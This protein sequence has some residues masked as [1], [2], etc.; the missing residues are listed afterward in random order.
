MFGNLVDRYQRSPEWRSLAPRTRILRE[1]LLL[2]ARAFLG[3]FSVASLDD[4]RTKKEIFSWRD[5]LADTPAKADNAIRTLSAMLSWAVERTEIEINW[6][7]KIKMLSPKAPR[8]K[9]T[10]TPGREEILLAT[11]P[12]PVNQLYRFA[13]FTLARESDIAAMRPENFDGRWLV[14]IPE[15]TKRKG[16]EVHLP[17]FEL[18]PLAALLDEIGS[19]WLRTSRGKFWTA[20]NI[21]WRFGDAVRKAFPGE[22]IDRTFH[23]IRGTGITRLMDA[24]C[25]DTETAAISGHALGRGSVLGNYIE[26]NR[27]QAVNAYRKWARAMQHGEADIIPFRRLGG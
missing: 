3:D 18:P 20:A 21:R 17:V 5:S 7:S 26:R 11:A 4:K 16:I 19:D 24:G 15:K 13:L 2:E 27:Q 14:F 10:W 8:A 1:A 12:R 23:D 9:M 22:D 25:S 6:A